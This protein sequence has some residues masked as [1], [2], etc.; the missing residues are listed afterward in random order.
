MLS[1]P[2]VCW[3]DISVFAVAVQ[4]CGS[5]NQGSG[6]YF[7]ENESTTWETSTLQD[8]MN[9]SFYKEAFSVEEK[10]KIRQVTLVNEDHPRWLS[11]GTF[12]HRFPDR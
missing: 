3:R 8:W 1:L 11:E 5:S 2:G 7:P 12:I 4:G 9:D 6:C 10:R